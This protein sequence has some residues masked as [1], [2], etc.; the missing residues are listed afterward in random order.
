VLEL[1]APDGAVPPVRAD[2]RRLRQILLN[3]VA[4]AVKF[5]D[6]G[7]VTLR[8][9]SAGGAGHV[10]FEVTDTGIGIEPLQQPHVFD[11]FFQADP[12]LTRRHGGAGLGLAISRRLARLMGGDL[13]VTS[14]TGRGSTFTLSLAAPRRRRGGQPPR[15]DRP[16]PERGSAAPT[17]AAT[18][19]GPRHGAPDAEPEV[20]GAGHRGRLRPDEATVAYLARTLY[21]DVRLVRAPDAGAWPRSPGGRRPRSSSSTSGSTAGRG[22]RWRTRCTRMPSSSRCRCSSCRRRARRAASPTRSTSAWSP[23]PPSSGS[24]ARRRRARRRVGPRRPPRPPAPRPTRSTPPP[25]SP[26][27]WAGRPRRRP[28]AAP[29]RAAIDVLVVDDDPDARRVTAEVLRAARRVVR[30]APDGE[31]ALA[32]MRGRRPDVAVIDLMMPVLDGFGVLAAMR[33]DARLRGVPVV[34]LTTKALTPESAPTWPARP[35]A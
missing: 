3:L 32:A 27:P 12:K 1:D 20:V 21:P 8:V 9:R 13:T 4:N 31:A 33:A 23:S 7:A 15:A 5:T 19:G 34:V 18:A 11:E 30:E 16:A 26:A 29:T 25:A 6:A 22:G 35:S 14:E 24:A 10:A 28:A 17:A 2:R